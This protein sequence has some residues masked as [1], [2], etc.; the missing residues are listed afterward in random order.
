MSEICWRTERSGPTFTTPDSFEIRRI[1]GASSE[2][3]T[4]HEH[5][6]VR[7][8]QVNRNYDKLNIT[9]QDCERLQFLLSIYNRQNVPALAD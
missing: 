5:M 9:E 6:H 7:H 4:M 8:A 3:K 2:E 1:W